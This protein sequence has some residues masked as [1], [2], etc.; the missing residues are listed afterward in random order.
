MR[1]RVRYRRILVSL[2]SARKEVVCDLRMLKLGLNTLAFTA[3][4]DCLLPMGI[5]NENVVEQ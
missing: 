5:T 3:A 4:K 2:I 1:Y